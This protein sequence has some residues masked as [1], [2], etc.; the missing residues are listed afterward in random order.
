MGNLFSVSGGLKLGSRGNTDRLPWKIYRNIISSQKATTTVELTM[1]LP[2]YK[3]FLKKRH[4]EVIELEE[5]IKTDSEGNRWSCLR[6]RQAFR[7]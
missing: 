2:I 5:E 6:R 7:S 3:D 4:P 1:E